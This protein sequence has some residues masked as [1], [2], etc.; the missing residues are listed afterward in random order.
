MKTF[1]TYTFLHLF[2]FY[3]LSSSS[4]R[5]NFG[6]S[7]GAVRFD[8]MSRTLWLL[9]CL[10]CWGLRFYLCF[11][12]SLSLRVLKVC[13]CHARR[14]TIKCRKSPLSSKSDSSDDKYSAVIT[15]TSFSLERT[16][17]C[18]FF[19][20]SQN[21]LKSCSSLSTKIKTSSKEAHSIIFCNIINVLHLAVY[22]I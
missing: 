5:M 9:N 21:L 18:F 10:L 13:F 6:Q 15:L 7:S 11:V 3:S 2:T 12:S 8:R 16:L 14:R 19:H 1:I 4:L 17:W 22:C 20:G